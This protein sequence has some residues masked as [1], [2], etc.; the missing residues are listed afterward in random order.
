MSDKDFN[1]YTALLDYA[2]FIY[3]F[4]MIVMDTFN[5]GL[6]D[7]IVV[8]DLA[9]N[10]QGTYKS[11]T[12]TIILATSIEDITEFFFVLVHEFAHN[13]IFVHNFYKLLNE[14]PHDVIFLH[15]EAMLLEIFLDLYYEG[16]SFVT[17]KF[18]IDLADFIYHYYDG[19]S[20]YIKELTSYPEFSRVRLPEF[21][22]EYSATLDADLIDSQLT[23]I[24]VARF[25]S[26]SSVAFRDTRDFFRN[27]N[28][29][30][31]FEFLKYRHDVFKSP[32]M[33]EEFTQ[34]ANKFSRYR[35]SFLRFSDIFIFN[36]SDMCRMG[37]IRVPYR[38]SKSDNPTIIDNGGEIIFQFPEV[39][40]RD[41]RVLFSYYSELKDQTICFCK[42]YKED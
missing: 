5:R 19:K 11:R 12:N 26:D 41:F 7:N 8:K 6:T 28:L 3:A 9:K 25:L 16:H 18:T 33:V 10:V 42:P 13:L 36:G 2:D 14:Y 23:L 15:V 30:I 34:V 40:M 37:Y 22:L 29:N 39:T 32:D 38:E 17:S 35:W 24:Q 4:K 27:I 1:V 31:S 21:L 20:T